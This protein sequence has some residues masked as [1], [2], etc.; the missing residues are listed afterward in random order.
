MSPFSKASSLMVSIGYKQKNYISE[1]LAK[2]YGYVKFC[3][4]NLWF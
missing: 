1:D 4:I 3:L 2:D